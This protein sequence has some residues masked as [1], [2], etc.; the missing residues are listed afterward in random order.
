MK[1]DPRVVL[2]P[3]LNVCCLMGAEVV[4][5]D[6]EVFILWRALFNMPQEFNELL[7]TMPIGY[8]GDHLTAENVKGGIQAGCSIVSGAVIPSTQPGA[9]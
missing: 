9:V 4:Q 3:L 6:V 2:Q 1:M 7:G 8:L 5:D